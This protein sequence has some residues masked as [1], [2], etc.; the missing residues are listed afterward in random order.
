MCITV[1]SALKRP[2][3]QIE[4]LKMEG[5]EELEY[6][7][8]LKNLF[9][10]NSLEFESSLDSDNPRPARVEKK[11]TESLASNAGLFSQETQGTKKVNTFTP[12]DKK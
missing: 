7:I 3:I 10:S 9:P 5:D 1:K 4:E 8:E 12:R 2:S 6:K 11:R